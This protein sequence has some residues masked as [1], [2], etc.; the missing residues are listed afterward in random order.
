M[1]ESYGGANSDKYITAGSWLQSIVIAQSAVINQ[2]S[3]SDY[4]SN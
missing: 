3:L 1:T 4:G 2:L